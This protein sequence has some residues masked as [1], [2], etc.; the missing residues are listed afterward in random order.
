[1]T[2]KYAKPEKVRRLVEDS[3][4]PIPPAPLPM[5]SP[6][7]KAAYYNLMSSA[8]HGHR[9]LYGVQYLF[10]QAALNISFAADL[11][12]QIATE[13]AIIETERGL[14]EHPASKLLSKT[15]RAI[16]SYIRTAR[17]TGTNDLRELKRSARQENDQRTDHDPLMDA[18]GS[19]E[20]RNIQ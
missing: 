6:M 10:A 15:E 2:I 3:S 17:A 20:P 18:G 4:K 14:R 12:K 8:P 9:S 11:R 13:G 1:M 7:A 5:H 16:E 19:E